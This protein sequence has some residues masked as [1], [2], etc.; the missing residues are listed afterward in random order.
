MVQNR[1]VKK[2]NELENA[3]SFMK[4]SMMN[5]CETN[6]NKTK[7][8]N[9]T[10]RL[11]GK[12]QWRTLK[13]KKSKNITLSWKEKLLGSGHLPPSQLLL[14]TRFMGRSFHCF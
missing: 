8:Q 7:Y 1:N 10:D 3:H 6:E 9:K 5:S 14:L 12:K 11:Q 2:T 13:M 4:G